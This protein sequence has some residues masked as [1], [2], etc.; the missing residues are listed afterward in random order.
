MVIKQTIGK[1]LGRKKMGLVIIFHY[2]I[3]LY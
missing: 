2:E 1:N 3:L